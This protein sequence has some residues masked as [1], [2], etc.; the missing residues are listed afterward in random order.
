MSLGWPLALPWGNRRMRL[1][2][3]ELH[4]DATCAVRPDGPGTCITAL[5]TL[6]A[7][8]VS[9]TAKLGALQSLGLL[10]P[11]FNPPCLRLE[12]LN[13]QSE[14]G[15]RLGGKGLVCGVSQSWWWSLLSQLTVVDIGKLLDL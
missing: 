8:L 3:S 15:H 12:V 10:A 9:S 13:F 6:N 1:S 5:S 2:V 11:V 4:D 7:P 14:V